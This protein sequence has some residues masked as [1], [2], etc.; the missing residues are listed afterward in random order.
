ML[1]VHAS[2]SF[3]SSFGTLKAVFITFGCPE[4]LLMISYRRFK[5]LIY[6]K[7]VDVAVF[8]FLSLVNLCPKPQRQTD[9]PPP[10]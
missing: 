9:L 4:T 3:T 7:Y 6:V 5:A 10:I 1:V 8:R 2:P